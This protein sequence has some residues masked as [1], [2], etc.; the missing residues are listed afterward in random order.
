MS[1]G[2]SIVTSGDNVGTV[3]RLDRSQYPLSV[4]VPSLS[5]P[6]EIRMEFATASGGPFGTLYR[7]DGSGLPHAVY[8]GAGPGWGQIDPPAGFARVWCGSGQGEETI[9]SVHGTR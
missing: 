1:V 5:A 7:A 4:R 2:Y 6:S 3:V 8:S 9:F